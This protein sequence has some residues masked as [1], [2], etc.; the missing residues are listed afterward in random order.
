M[1][2]Q[3]HLKPPKSAKSILMRSE[4][5]VVILLMTFILFLGYQQVS[6]SMLNV[7]FNRFRIRLLP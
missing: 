6:S 5:I 1:P 7:I 4:T 3:T 2:E